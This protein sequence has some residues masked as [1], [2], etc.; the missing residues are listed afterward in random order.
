MV[1]GGAQVFTRAYISEHDAVLVALTI[2][3]GSAVYVSSLATLDPPLVRE[4][5]RF[6][7]EVITRS[8]AR[9]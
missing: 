4:F 9:P 3:V 7:R 5:L 6:L 2:L 8:P 1:A